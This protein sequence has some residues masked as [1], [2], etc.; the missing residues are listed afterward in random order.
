MDTAVV[1]AT[2]T[3]AILC[4]PPTVSTLEENASAC[5]AR[6]RATVPAS[7]RNRARV[8]ALN[9]LENLL[10]DVKCCI[11]LSIARQPIS[12]P[13]NHF[14]CGE[15]LAAQM[16]QETQTEQAMR[17]AKSNAS[18]KREMMCPECRHV[19]TRRT[20]VADPVII[21]MADLCERLARQADVQELRSKG[22]LLKSICVR[23]P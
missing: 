8:A 14:F 21:T 20:T 4:T 22:L 6:S 11:C 15:C 13:C 3:T 2:T 9:P 5:A 16:R 7:A 17:K 19:Y 1:A 12:L 10:K 23:T 18:L